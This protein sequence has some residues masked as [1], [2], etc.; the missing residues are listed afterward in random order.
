MSYPYLKSSVNYFFIK[1]HSNAPFSETLSRTHDSVTRS[2]CQPSRFTLQFRVCPISSEPFERFS[3]NFTQMFLLVR[4]CVEPMTLSYA[5]SRSRLHFEVMGFCSAGFSCPSKCG[6]IQ[7]MFLVSKLAP[8]E[9]I[10]CFTY[11]Y[12]GGKSKHL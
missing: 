3:L 5:D 12:I 7:F 1:L 4:Q 11:E 10:T 8:P 9:G 6:I 2:Q